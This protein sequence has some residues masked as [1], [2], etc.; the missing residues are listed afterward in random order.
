MDTVP[1]RDDMEGIDQR[2]RAYIVYATLRQVD[3]HAAP[4][5]RILRIR[6]LAQC[7]EI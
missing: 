5:R 7:G 2:A 3:L 4:V 6:D 1:G